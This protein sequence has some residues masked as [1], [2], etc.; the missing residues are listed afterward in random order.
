L[1]NRVYKNYQINVGTPFSIKSPVNFSTIKTATLTEEDDKDDYAEQLS[2]KAEKTLENARQQSDTIIMEAQT[3]AERIIDDAKRKAEEL[4][5]QIEEQ[6]RRKGYEDGYNEGREKYEALIKEAEQI[7][8]RTKAEY[9]SM[10]KG[11]EKDV[12]RLVVDIAKKVLDT[13]LSINKESILSLISEAVNK[14]S[15]SNNII[16]KVSSEDYDYVIENKG[17]LLSMLDECD[18]AEIKKDS[19]L[20][21]GACIV[22]TN[23]GS[24]DSGVG[25]KLKKIEE[26]FAQLIGKTE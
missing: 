14:C 21:S 2:K 3:E 16:L 10:L 18:E 6:F 12:V 17:K 7:K 23:F 22:E 26:A 8:S 11:V 15:C 5:D 19:S 4:A 1:S 9:V 25:T 20:C 13:E 24:V